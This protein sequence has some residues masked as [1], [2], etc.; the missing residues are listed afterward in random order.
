M[1]SHGGATPEG[2]T[3]VLAGL[4]I[5]EDSVECAIRAT[6]RTVLIGHTENGHP[7]YLDRNVAEAGGFFIINR[8]KPH[9]DFHAKHESGLLKMLAI[10]LGKEDGASFMHSTGTQG[11]KT[12]M[13]EVGAY[14][15]EHTNLIAGLAT[16]EDGYHQPV[17]LRVLTPDAL[18]SGELELLDKARQLMP[19]LPVDEIDLLIVDRLG[20]DISGTGMDTN[21]IGRIYI[22]GEAEPESPNVKALIILDVSEASHGN[23]IGVGLAD[24]TVERLLKKIDFPQMTKNVFTSGFLERGRI[25]LVFQTDEAAIEAALS[26][27]FRANIDLIQQARV[28]RIS[29]TLNLEQVWVSQ[30]LLDEVQSSEGFLEAAPPEPLIFHDGHLF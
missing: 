30:A 25:P 23:A 24:F 6:M 2:Q 8:V 15:L 3:E 1:G 17:H 5:T 11:L 7:A 22:P 13:P 29:D 4:G 10:G 16:V 21:V 20:K 28:M 14:L 9:T 18:I 19:R 12:Y 26:H 27:V